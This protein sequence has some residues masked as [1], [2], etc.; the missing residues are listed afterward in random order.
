MES[1]QIKLGRFGNKGPD[2]RVK[3]LKLI[4]EAESLSEATEIAHK[5]TSGI[6]NDFECISTRDLESLERISS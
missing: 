6:L 4:V 3:N 5:L 1:F 2:K